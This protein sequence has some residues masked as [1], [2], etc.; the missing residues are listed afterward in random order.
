MV[1]LALPT[2]LELPGDAPARPWPAFRSD[3]TSGVC[4]E[5]FA[6]L[7]AENVG[8]RPAYG[9]DPLTQRLD[10]AFSALFERPVVA[11]PVLTGT[12]ANALA[13]STV[14]QPYSSVVCHEAAH[15]LLDEAGA[16]EFYGDLRLAP[17]RGPLGKLDPEALTAA[18]GGRRS[19]GALTLAAASIAQATESGTV[20]TPEEVAALGAAAKAHS[21]ALHMDGAR[22][23]NAI[24]ALGCAPADVTWRAG[25]DVLSFGATKNGALIAEAVIFFAPERAADFARRRKRGGHALS[26]SRFVSAQLL[27]YLADDL[28]LRN[29]AHANA[30]TA[31]LANGLEKLAGVT[32]RTPPQ[33]NQLFV[34][35]SAPLLTA[36]ATEGVDLFRWGGE[37]STLVRLVTAFSTSPTEVDAFVDLVRRSSRTA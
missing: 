30:M 28:W 21:M 13:L 23:A 14:A 20:Y 32:L 5:I 2:R 12:A 36:L 22:F 34:D 35:M 7:A 17:T 1:G 3:N 24:A 26:K 16:P 37:A 33:T 9:Q 15:I 29:A 31:R 18:I 19:S 8:D 11:F 10:A 4:P 6:A 27:A 25:V